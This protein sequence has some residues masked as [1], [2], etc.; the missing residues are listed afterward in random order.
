[1]N[2]VGTSLVAPMHQDNDTF[3]HTIS[4]YSGQ[5]NNSNTPTDTTTDTGTRSQSSHNQTTSAG[6]VLLPFLL[7][8]L[9]VQVLRLCYS[10]GHQ[11]N[12]HRLC[13]PILL[14]LPLALIPH[15]LVIRLL[16][17]T[18][19]RL[20]LLILWQLLV[21][22]AFPKSHCTLDHHNRQI[23]PIRGQV[24]GT[25]ILYMPSQQRAY[26][27]NMNTKRW[28]TLAPEEA[29]MLLSWDGGDTLAAHKL[30]L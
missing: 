3:S 9:C 26:N 1:M 4:W 10:L 8:A 29:M 21:L 28:P 6:M 5:Q 12:Q 14:S 23:L 22:S 13:R 7:L 24:L 20:K 15:K 30:T 11:R 19:N 18:L 25:T 16:S 2:T 27:V 17:L